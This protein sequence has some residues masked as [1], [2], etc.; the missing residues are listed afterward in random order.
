MFILLL[1]LNMFYAFFSVSIIRFEQVIL[2]VWQKMKGYTQA[3]LIHTM[4]R[5]IWNSLKHLRWSMLRKQ[6][7]AF[8]R[9]L[10]LQGA[11]SQ[12][13]DRVLNTPQLDINNF[14]KVMEIYYETV[15]VSTYLKI[16]LLL[17][18]GAFQIMAESHVSR[19]LMKMLW[20][21]FNSCQF[22]LK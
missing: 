16:L 4:Q 22:V 13:F 6:L 21:F 5:S 7:T 14:T 2:L 19:F 18:L 9:Q 8:S 17:Y 3:S 10:F 15:V 20:H 1:I 12:M 11:P